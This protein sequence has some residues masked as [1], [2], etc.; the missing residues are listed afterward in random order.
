MWQL[1]LRFLCRRMGRTLLPNG[2][3][4]V[5]ALDDGGR[6]RAGSLTLRARFCYGDLEGE[7][8]LRG[9]A[10]FGV[11]GELAVG[12]VEGDGLGGAEAGDGGDFLFG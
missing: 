6:G 9:R 1:L 4:S 10:G 8:V 12:L 7:G 3:G 2:R 11:D 5:G